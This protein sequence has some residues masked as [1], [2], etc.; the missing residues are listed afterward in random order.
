MRPTDLLAIIAAAKKETAK[1]VKDALPTIADMVRQEVDAKEI[2]T[3]ADTAITIK[4]DKG[5]DG[6]QGPIGPQGPKGDKGDRGETGP[7]GAT[8]PAGPKGDTGDTGPAGPAGATGATG[9]GVATGGTTGQVL[10]KTSA[11]DF[12]TGWVDVFRG[13]SLPLKPAAGV[14]IGPATSG[15]ALGTVA[16][17]ANR[18]T[19][20]PFCPAIDTAIDQVGISVSTAVASSLAKVVIYSSDANGRPGDLVAESGNIDCST[21]GT[22]F[23]SLSVSFVAGRVYWIGVR[24]SS[25]QTL[26]SLPAAAFPVISY[27]NAATPLI[28]TVLLKSETYANAAASW[29]YSSAHHSNQTVPLVL[30]RVA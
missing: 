9:P 5:D 6:E 24:S 28:Q 25:T 21:T 13:L 7:A 11:T 26:R 4:G 16:Q 15:V 27:T 30:M 23:V 1:A 8:G 20:A 17:A 29:G 12:A 2:K 14:F 18:N 22:K 10:A 19:V 3:I